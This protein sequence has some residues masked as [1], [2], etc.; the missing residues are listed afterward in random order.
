MLLLRKLLLD[1][2][3]LK[4]K[5]ILKWKLDKRLSGELKFKLKSN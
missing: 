4:K 5:L 2:Q 3:D 1:A